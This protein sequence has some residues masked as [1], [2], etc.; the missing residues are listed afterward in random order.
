MMQ[1]RKIQRL[2]QD[3][4]HADASKRRNAAEV[5]AEADERAV[6]PL[7]RALRDENHGVQDAAMRSLIAIGGETVAYMVL[8]LLREDSYLRNT[9]MIMLRDIGP[10]TVP[11]LYPLLNDK[12]DDVRKFSIDL[13]IDIQFDVDAEKIVPM[14]KDPNANVRASAA[15]ALGLLGFQEAVPQLV[16]ILSDEEW[17]CFSALE[18]LGA[19]RDEAA[20]APIVALLTGDSVTIRYAAI[21]TLGKIG[22]PLAQG[23]L[24]QHMQTA[25]D[26]EK[27]AALKSLLQIGITPTVPGTVDLLISMFREGDWDERFI[28]LRGLAELKDPKAVRTVID[29]SGSLEPSDPEAEDRLYMIRSALREFATCVALIDV[30]T[31]PSIRFRG[32]VI[33]I[34]QIGEL[35][36]EQAI[37]HLIKCIEVDVRDVR[38]ASVKALAG[39]NDQESTTALIDA[40]DDYD[41]HVRKAAVTALGQISDP[42]SFEPVLQMV[43]VEKY[44]DVLEEAVKAL[45]NID[46]AAVAARMDVFDERVRGIVAP[47]LQ[48]AS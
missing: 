41:S 27:A 45:V 38:R 14:L 32:R 5:L 34:E 24:E 35:K 21:E 19:L 33:A 4:A 44:Q 40:V 18:A 6:Y 13:M 10:V 47:Y 48:E 15:K 29:I 23:A 43:Q 37:S 20:V 8:P 12:D 3:L 36:C 25:D 11:F 9:A 31:D 30:L 17:V 42:R 7:L 2:L 46:R 22:S 1:S 28:A 26:M 16:A 39:I